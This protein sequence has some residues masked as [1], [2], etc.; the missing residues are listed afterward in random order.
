MSGD[1]ALVS[2]T[3]AAE[4]DEVVSF[5]GIDMEWNRHIFRHAAQADEQAFAVVVRALAEAVRQ[6]RRFGTAARIRQRIMDGR[7]G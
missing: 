6:D 2:A 3:T 7:N 4:L 1:V 5:F